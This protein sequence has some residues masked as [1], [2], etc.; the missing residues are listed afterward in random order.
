M[1]GPWKPEV[2]SERQLEKLEGASVHF[3]ALGFD[4]IPNRSFQRCPGFEFAQVEE[5]RVCRSGQH[6]ALGAE[7][8]WLV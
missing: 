3:S 1:S 2:V 4:P 7:E 6:P 5:C 8:D